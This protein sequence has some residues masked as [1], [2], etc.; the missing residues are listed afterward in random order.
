MILI[1]C[2]NCKSDDISFHYGDH[3]GKKGIRCN[4]CGA[5][6]NVPACSFKEV[7]SITKFLKN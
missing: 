5:V 2:V 7:E 6:F 4:M 1:L 3:G